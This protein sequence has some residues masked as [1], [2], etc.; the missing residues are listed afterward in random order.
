MKRLIYLIGQPGSG[1]S[2]L[3]ARLTKG[4][5]RMPAPGNPAR[6][7]LIDQRTGTVAAV[8]L[9]RRRP[10]GFSGTDALPS[11][12]IEKAIPWLGK[13]SEAQLVLGEGARLANA[14]FLG[15]AKDFG[16]RILL[17]HLEHGDAEPWR[18]QRSKALGKVQ[19]ES[20][21]RGRRSASANLAASPPEGTTVFAGHPDELHPKI[22][23]W[24]EK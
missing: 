2:T 10:G 21:V 15:S 3:M 9:G 12:I 1:K 22:V 19:N 23:S 24:W 4:F 13:Q 7:L 17:V 14:R 11:T 16:Y 20:W 5:A 18:L 8:E 6:D